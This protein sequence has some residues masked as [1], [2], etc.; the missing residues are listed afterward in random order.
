MQYQSS[1]VTFP[2]IVAVPAKYYKQ[3]IPVTPNNISLITQDKLIPE[4][5]AFGPS[6]NP[7]PVTSNNTSLLSPVTSPQIITSNQI[8]SSNHMPSTNQI[9]PPTQTLSASQILSDGISAPESPSYTTM[10]MYSSNR[11]STYKDPSTFER[12]IYNDPSTFETSNLDSSLDRQAGN[13]ESVIRQVGN[14]ECNTDTRQNE[15][16]SKPIS[17]LKP[18][19]QSSFR[20]PRDIP[21][22]DTTN[23]RRILPTVVAT[24]KSNLVKSVSSRSKTDLDVVRSIPINTILKLDNMET[25]VYMVLPDKITWDT[26]LTAIV[27]TSD[28]KVVPL[29]VMYE[30]RIIDIINRINPS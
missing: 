20:H 25:G 28:G 5:P 14:R 24:S 16:T 1:R 17:N 2:D 29:Q 21:S 13:R 30:D 4:L 12:A 18:S 3:T 19:T 15:F 10:P 9:L 6:M 8:L 27:K 23:R 22:L 11:Q 7:G 26:G